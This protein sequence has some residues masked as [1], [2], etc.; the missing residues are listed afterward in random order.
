MADAVPIHHYVTH[1]TPAAVP[2]PPYH[3]VPSTPPPGVTYTLV[4]TTAL[5]RHF[6]R[7]DHNPHHHLCELD[8]A[9]LNG[10]NTASCSRRLYNAQNKS[11]RRKVNLGYSAPGRW[12][13]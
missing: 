9:D 10:V 8:A 13:T 11:L 12:N 5:P 3:R 7:Y 1:N 6:Q 4:A 2:L